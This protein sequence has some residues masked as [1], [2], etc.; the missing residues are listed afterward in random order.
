MLAPCQQQTRFLHCISCTS[1]I[2]SISSDLTLLLNV[3]GCRLSWVK[4][5]TACIFNR[6]RS[7]AYRF[8]FR[9]CLLS[10]ASALLVLNGV[11]KSPSDVSIL[12]RFLTSKEADSNSSWRNPSSIVA[13]TDITLSKYRPAIVDIGNGAESV[14]C[15]DFVPGTK[16]PC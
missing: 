14:P 5:V 12:I 8:S 16:Q 4:N 7:V 15:L 2:V 11:P 3:C 10:C 1:I 13:R 6:I 9:R